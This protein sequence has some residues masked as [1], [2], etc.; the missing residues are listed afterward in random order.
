[1]A[2]YEVLED[3]YPESINMLIVLSQCPGGLTATDVRTLVQNYPDVFGEFE[4]IF[5][6]SDRAQR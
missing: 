1:M 6:D 5:M 3:K 2:E 4:P